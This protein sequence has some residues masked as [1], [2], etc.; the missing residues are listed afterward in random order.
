MMISKKAVLFFDSGG[1]RDDAESA[2]L[3]Y[4]FSCAP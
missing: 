2:E 3:V 1:F 4:D